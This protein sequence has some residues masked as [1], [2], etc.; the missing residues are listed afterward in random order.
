MS[1]ECNR[2]FSTKTNGKQAQT[3]EICMGTHLKTWEVKKLNV[4]LFTTRV[5]TGDLFWAT[6]ISTHRSRTDWDRL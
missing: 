1:A 3:E 6:A 4:K 5:F 2:T